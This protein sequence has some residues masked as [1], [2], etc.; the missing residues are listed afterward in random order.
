[1]NDTTDR[2]PRYGLVDA[3]YRDEVINGLLDQYSSDSAFA[4]RLWWLAKDHSF[5]V[6]GC[7]CCDIYGTRP[8]WSELRDISEEP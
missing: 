5:A 1:M 6:N 2:W 3:F 8:G 4:T 7:S